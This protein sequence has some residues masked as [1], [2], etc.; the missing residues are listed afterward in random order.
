MCWRRLSYPV[1]SHLIFWATLI[2]VSA[3]R[4]MWHYQPIRFGFQTLQFFLCGP[5]WMCLCSLTFSYPSLSLSPSQVV[6]RREVCASQSSPPLPEP[7][8]TSTLMRSCMTPLLWWLQRTTATSWSRFASFFWLWLESMSPL[9]VGCTHLDVS[10][11]CT[12]DIFWFEIHFLWVYFW[13][14]LWTWPCSFL[15][16]SHLRYLPSLLSHI[17]LSVLSDMLRVRWM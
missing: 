6:W 4:P 8:H 7:P 9:C 13:F 11:N 10:T 15:S 12:F 16:S 14:P 17:L 5:V 2:F 1:C 3:Q